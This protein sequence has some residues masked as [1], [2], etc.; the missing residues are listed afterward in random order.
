VRG[1]Q[2]E[3]RPP[4]S[5][6]EE[7]QRV[8]EERTIR[9]ARKP[10]VGSFEPPGCARRLLAGNARIKRAGGLKLTSSP[11]PVSQGGRKDKGNFSSPQGEQTRNG[12]PRAYGVLAFHSSEKGGKEIRRKE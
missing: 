5:K 8:K 12:H 2:L 3:N 11:A 7:F 10:S 4:Q 1:G 9:I 6:L